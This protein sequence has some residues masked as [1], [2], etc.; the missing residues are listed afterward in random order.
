MRVRHGH[1][2][3]G[4]VSRVYII[5]ANM[6]K[7]CNYINY[8][9]YDDYGGRGI[10]VCERWRKFENFL[11]DMGEPSTDQHQIDRINNNGNYCKSNCK[12][13]TRQ[14]Q[15]KNKRNNHLIAFCGKIQC[16][17]A[18]AEELGINH[19]TLRSRLFLGWSTEKALTT[20]TRK[21]RK[22]LCPV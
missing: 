19:R 8:Q 3:R 14:E 4:K 21:R 13:V 22:L 12:W 16:L 6:I 10:T 15:G 18:W 11:E 2:E 20:P 17:S 1:S 9:H 5:W 7:R